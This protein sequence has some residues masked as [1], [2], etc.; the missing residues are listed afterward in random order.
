MRVRGKLF[1]TPILHQILK[2]SK[3]RQNK[4]DIL[5]STGTWVKVKIRK[6]GMDVS[7]RCKSMFASLL[8]TE[9][10]LFKTLLRPREPL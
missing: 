9:I 7:K 6:P 3:I 4:T 8:P 2:C 5:G 1:P 10:P